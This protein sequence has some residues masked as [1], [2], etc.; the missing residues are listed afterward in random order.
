MSSFRTS[1]GVIPDIEIINCFSNIT[2]E[3][4]I[5][6]EGI[7]LEFSNGHSIIMNGE[8][9]TLTKND[10]IVMHFTKFNVA[11]L[12]PN[13]LFMELFRYILP[14]KKTKKMMVLRTYDDNCIIC[15][16]KC[17]K[18]YMLEGCQC[19]YGCHKK[20]LEKWRK[21]ENSCPICRV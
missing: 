16:E 17:K 10:E 15:F 5:K 7:T 2:R 3:E 4:Y 6:I 1:E 13:R 20:C 12:G 18:G 21:N 11:Y 19:A 9:Y 14:S 8:G